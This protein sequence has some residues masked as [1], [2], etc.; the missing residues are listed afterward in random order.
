MLHG[1]DGARFSYLIRPRRASNERSPRQ[2]WQVQ[3]YLLDAFVSVIRIPPPS[4]RIGGEREGAA[5]AGFQWRPWKSPERNHGKTAPKIDAIS[6]PSA[7]SVRTFQVS[8]EPTMRRTQSRFKFSD[9]SIPQF[10]LNWANFRQTISS[11]LRLPAATPGTFPR[12]HISI[13]HLRRRILC[14]KLKPNFSLLHH[15][16]YLRF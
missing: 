16:R 9:N 7:L 6:E 4:T 11:D 3:Q 10:K 2:L 12:P 5:S 14:G 15:V 1:V 13:S 8:T